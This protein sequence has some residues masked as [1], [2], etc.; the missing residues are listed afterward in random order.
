MA[1]TNA[2]SSRRRAASS[3]TNS[4]RGSMP[5][6]GNVTEPG[7]R[8]GGTETTNR[9]K[10]SGAR[11][12][13]KTAGPATGSRTLATSTGVGVPVPTAAGSMVTVPRGP[14]QPQASTSAQRR[15]RWIATRLSGPFRTAEQRGLRPASGKAPARQ[16]TGD[17][18]GQ[19]S[20]WRHLI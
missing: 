2:F 18:V 11:P 14:A 15:P 4:V 20:F 5:G 10:L 1:A 12:G 8:S 3:V 19:Q 17:A 16:F 6:P 9:A 7:L 13:P